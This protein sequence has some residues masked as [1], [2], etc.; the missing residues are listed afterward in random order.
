[1]VDDVIILQQLNIDSRC[2][3]ELLQYV[4]S[5]TAS[6]CCM[7]LVIAMPA[8]DDVVQASSEVVRRSQTAATPT[9]IYVDAVRQRHPSGVDDRTIQNR[10][11]QLTANPAYPRNPPLFEVDA[12]LPWSVSADVG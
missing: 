9:P 12:D 2:C 6:G 5:R 8:D 1:V 3:N 10:K 4:L 11:P 7:R